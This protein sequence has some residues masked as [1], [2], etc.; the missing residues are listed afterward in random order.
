MSSSF[1]EAKSWWPGTALVVSGY[2]AVG[3]LLLL[4]LEPNLDV[5]VFSLWG[6]VKN[7]F[8]DLSP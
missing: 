4:F 6:V 2:E 5:K 7:G 8:Q 3:V 1:F